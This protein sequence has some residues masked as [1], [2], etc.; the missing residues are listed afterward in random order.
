MI[1]TSFL[2]LHFARQISSVVLDYMLNTDRSVFSDSLFDKPNSAIKCLGFRDYV[3]RFLFE[4]RFDS[5]L[6]VRLTLVN[7]TDVVQTGL[8]YSKWN[9]QHDLN[10]YNRKAQS[11]LCFQVMPCISPVFEN[12]NTV[13]KISA[14]VTSCCHKPVSRAFLS[15]FFEN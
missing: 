7:T 11:L 4:L 2:P 15:E 6:V 1:L 12:I 13:T 9:M 10:Q 14:R 8:S 3:N 5:G